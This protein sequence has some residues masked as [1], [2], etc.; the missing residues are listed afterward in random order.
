VTEAGS[1][2]EGLARLGGAAVRHRAAGPGAARPQRLGG[3]LEEDAPGE[4][5]GVEVDG[6]AVGPDVRVDDDVGLQQV[7]LEYPLDGVYAVGG[8]ARLFM[9]VTNTG[10]EPVTL[11]DISGPDF[12]GMR[13]ETAE[14]QGL[15]LTVDADDNLYVGGRGAAGRHPAGPGSGAALLAVRPR[16]PHVRRG[17]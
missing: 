5:P 2:E 12:S 3:R 8:D 15:P 7:Q 13:V 10:G 9:A 14:G 6:G 1:G 11:T 4:D 16:H 17:R